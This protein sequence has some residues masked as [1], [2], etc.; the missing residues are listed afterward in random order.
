MFM[1]RYSLSIDRNR[2]TSAECVEIWHISIALTKTALDEWDFYLRDPIKSE[3]FWLD[4]KYND[5]R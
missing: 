1:R 5:R 4:D 3:P 2:K